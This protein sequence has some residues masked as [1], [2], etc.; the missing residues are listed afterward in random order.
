MHGDLGDAGRARGFAR[1][2]LAR[3]GAPVSLIDDVLLCVSEV[4]TNA[5]RHAAGAANLR[6]G[7]GDGTVRVEVLDR[8]AGELAA[9]D[10]GPLATSGRGLMIIERVADRWGVRPEAGGMKAV[11]FEFDLPA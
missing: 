6:I 7:V 5:V 9:H 3:H 11:W 2:V 1:T 4:V 10:P 8:V